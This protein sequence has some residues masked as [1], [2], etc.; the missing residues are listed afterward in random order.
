MRL[1]AKNRKRD[2]ELAVSKGIP[3]CEVRSHHY[4]AVIGTKKARY[5]PSYLLKSELFKLTRACIALVLVQP[6]GDELD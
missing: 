5:A 2:C 4:A 1:L 6:P 3:C